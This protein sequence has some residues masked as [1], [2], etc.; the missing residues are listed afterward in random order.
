MPVAERSNFLRA[1][2]GDDAAARGAVERLLA[3]NQTIEGGATADM[4]AEASERLES[5]SRRLVE[6]SAQERS[7]ARIFEG[8]C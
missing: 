6:I 2:F 5:V 1:A 8:E 3:E 4:G 7:G